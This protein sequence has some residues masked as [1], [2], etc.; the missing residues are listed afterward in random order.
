MNT[1]ID[2]AKLLRDYAR[3]RSESVF[4]ELVQRHL[5]LVYRV[6]LRQTGGDAHRAKDVVQLVFTLVARKA[7][8]LAEHLSFVG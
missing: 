2:D 1:M 3:K 7:I 8:V 5:N 4:G 6:A